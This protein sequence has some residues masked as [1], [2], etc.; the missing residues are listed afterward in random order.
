MSKR[1]G[2]RGRSISIHKQNNNDKQNTE[3]ARTIK[4]KIRCCK[5]IVNVVDAKVIFFTLERKDTSRSL[6][7][8]KTPDSRSCELTCA[9]GEGL[10]HGCG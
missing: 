4:H 9:H 10:Y 1:E 8:N 2:P 3:K 7:W 6:D 5:C